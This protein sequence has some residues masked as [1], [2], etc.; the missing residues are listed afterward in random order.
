[1]QQPHVSLNY[2]G[3]L[4]DIEIFVVVLFFSEL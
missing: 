2:D 4:G 3:S 1:V